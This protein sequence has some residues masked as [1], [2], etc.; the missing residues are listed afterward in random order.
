MVIFSFADHMVLNVM[1]HGNNRLNPIIPDDDE[2]IAIAQHFVFRLGITI[3]KVN[4]RSCLQLKL[5]QSFNNKC[6]VNLR[7][8]SN[9]DIFSCNQKNNPEY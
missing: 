9:R 8:E 1:A 7:N 5:L 2:A 6:W 4:E 3:G